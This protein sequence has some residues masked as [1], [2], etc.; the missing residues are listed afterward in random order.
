LSVSETRGIAAAMG[1][2]VSLTLNPGYACRRLNPGDACYSS[3]VPIILAHRIIISVKLSKISL[4]AT[5]RLLKSG[6][7]RRAN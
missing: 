5:A 4:E 2:R 1:P 7:A 6:E 3:L